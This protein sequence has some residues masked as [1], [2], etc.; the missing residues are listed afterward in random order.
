[1]KDRKKIEGNK[2]FRNS[3]ILH[4]PH[5]SVKIQNSI[6]F[7]KDKRIIQ[8]EI[9]KLTDWN[10]NEIFSIPEITTIKAEFSRIFCD[11]ERFYPDEDEEMSKFGRGF[12]Y[13]KTDNG[14]HLREDIDGIKGYVYENYYLPHHSKLTQAVDKKLLEEGTA[15]IIDCHSFSD[16]PFNT[17]IDKRTPRPDICIGIDEFHTPDFL[18]E[19]F[20]SIFKNNGLTVAINS[21][22][23]GTMIPTKFYKNEENVIGIMIEVNK[24]LYMNG[25]CTVDLKNIL[26]LNKII[27]EVIDN[28]I[29]IK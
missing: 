25:L 16:K 1:M 27:V 12:F 20:K 6:G 21:P 22:Y 15:Y 13:T 23:S 11:V 24:R 29:T 10:T 2:D 17:D 9:L 4:I 28:F 8:D 18:K 14:L 26:K 3:V 19:H 5:S 7:T